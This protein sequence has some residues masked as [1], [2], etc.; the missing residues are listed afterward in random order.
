MR[1]PEYIAIGLGLGV[2]AFVWSKREPSTTGPTGQTT[3]PNG[4][5]PGISPEVQ[6]ALDLIKKLESDPNVDPT[7]AAITLELAANG[8]RTTNPQAAE[9]LDAAAAR[10]RKR[11]TGP[12]PGPG[13]GPD[14]SP[15]IA[16]LTTRYNNLV[17]IGNAYLAGTGDIS[18]ARIDEMTR[19]VAE[20]GTAQRFLDAANLTVI[21]GAVRAKK[22]LPRTFAYPA[23]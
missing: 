13:P 15:P 14:P 9:I 11:G 6:Q 4:Q 3:K 7:I 16:D 18:E 17:T 19:T 8:F 21:E 1:Q 23:V 2:L 10:M 5:F 20:L 22:G 12:N